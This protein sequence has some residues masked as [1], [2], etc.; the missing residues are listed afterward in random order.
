MQSVKTDRILRA[1]IGLL[2]V[3]LVYVI[4]AAIHEHVVVAGDRYRSMLDDG[5][6]APQSPGPSAL[7]ERA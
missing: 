5:V 6:L 4:S 1:A 7:S 2:V 3:V